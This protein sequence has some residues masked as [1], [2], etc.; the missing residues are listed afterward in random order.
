M[1]A[2]KQD[3]GIWSKASSRKLLELTKILGIERQVVGKQLGVSATTIWF[4]DSGQ[5]PIPAKYH[6][7]LSTWT[8]LALSQARAHMTKE[9]QSLPTPALQVAAIEAFEAPIMQWY[10]EVAYESG[11]AEASARKHLR[12]L[13]DF[14][15]KDPWTPA[16]I[17]QI[18]VLW[19]GLGSKLQL[20]RDMTGPEGASTTREQHSE[21]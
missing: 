10:L 5:R 12:W 14:L 21:G 7:A 15:D 20:L 13:R 16:D 1:A 18:Q 6:Q 9:A 3:T 11:E 8:A 2:P 19:E 4:W 17:E